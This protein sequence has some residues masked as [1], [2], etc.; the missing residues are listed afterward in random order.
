MANPTAASAPATAIIYSEKSWPIKSSKKTENTTKLK[1]TDK[2]SISIDTIVKIIFL[3]VTKIPKMLKKN[4]V[5]EKN[6]KSLK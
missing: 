5:I 4:N 3:R 6:K 1:L 2:N